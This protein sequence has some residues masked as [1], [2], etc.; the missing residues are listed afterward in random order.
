[1]RQTVRETTKRNLGKVCV[2][3]GSTESIEYHHI[4]PLALGGNDTESNM[5]AL[6]H[7]CH[8]AAHCGRHMSHYANTTNPGRKSKIEKPYAYYYMGKYVNGEIGNK[9]LMQVLGYKG[10]SPKSISY[11]KKY[12][13]EHGMKSVK[14]TV[15]VVATTGANGLYSGICVGEIEYVD[16]TLEKITYKDTGENDVYYKVRELPKK[17]NKNLKPKPKDKPRRNKAVVNQEGEAKPKRKYRKKILKEIDNHP[18]DFYDSYE[19]VIRES[20]NGMKVT[21]NF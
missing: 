13:E 9:K 5:V 18:L 14:N 19:P 1:M 6:C 3:C 17:E 2:N 8:K 20:I 11:Y 10:I 12:L 16:G 4:V 7:Q 21:M 15:D